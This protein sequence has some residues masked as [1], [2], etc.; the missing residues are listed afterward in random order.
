MVESSGTPDLIEDRVIAA[1]ITARAFPDWK[2]RIARS[3]GG[4]RVSMAGISEEAWQRAFGKKRK[5]K[6]K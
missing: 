3:S 6:G 1:H 4:A 5:K 2:T